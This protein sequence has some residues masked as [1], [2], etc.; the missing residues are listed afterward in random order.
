METLTLS[1]EAVNAYKT[2]LQDPVAYKMDFKPLGEV[3]VK[4]D[5]ITAQHIL[6]NEF[7]AYIKRP[8][9]K[10]I[11]YIILN[12]IYGMTQGNDENGNAGYY[13]KV[14]P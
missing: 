4:S 6:F 1:P 13:L 14:Q 10:V 5:K 2:I 9:P 7:A 3:L 12:E 11:F 8:L